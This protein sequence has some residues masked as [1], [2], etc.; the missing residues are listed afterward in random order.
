M[1]LNTLPAA[2]CLLLLSA[3]STVPPS[4]PAKIEPPPVALVMEC[5]RPGDLPE[6]ATAKDL[7]AWALEWIGAYGCE[8]SKRTALIESWPR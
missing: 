5:L 8:K 7:A 1:P 3:C 6:P 2:L 4:A